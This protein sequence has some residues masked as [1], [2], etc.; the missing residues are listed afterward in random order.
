MNSTCKL[1]TAQILVLVDIKKQ[2]FLLCKGLEAS[3]CIDSLEENTAISSM[4]TEKRLSFS[5]I[6]E[7]SRKNVQKFYPYQANKPIKK[8]T[9]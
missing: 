5:S 1:L 2:H 7:K 4:E 8:V 3:T 9:R 6:S